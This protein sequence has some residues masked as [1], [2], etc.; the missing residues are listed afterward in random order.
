[1]NFVFQ[2]YS[3]WIGWMSTDE[4]GEAVVKNDGKILW[5]LSQSDLVKRCADVCGAVVIE[6][7]TIFD[8]DKVLHGLCSRKVSSDEVINCWNMLKDVRLALGAF[9]A[10]YA[11]EGIAEDRAYMAFFSATSGGELVGLVEGQVADRDFEVAKEVVSNG[12]LMLLDATVQVRSQ[13]PR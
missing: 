10:V 12:V 6:S 8:M 2:S 11:L 13:G 3:I 7:A 4:P 5:G 1:M 9:R